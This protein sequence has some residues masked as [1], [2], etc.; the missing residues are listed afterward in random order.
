[1]FVRSTTQLFTPPH[2]DSQLHSSVPRYQAAITLRG[3]TTDTGRQ[4]TDGPT[5][6]MEG[7]GREGR[8]VPQGSNTVHI[9]AH[10][11]YSQNCD[12]SET[13]NMMEI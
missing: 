13:V 9:F 2:R 6:H 11:H 7:I 4:H 1:M 5:G 12:R 3:G 10:P 8:M